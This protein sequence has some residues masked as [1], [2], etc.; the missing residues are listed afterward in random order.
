[1]ADT[2]IA[3]TAGSGTSVDTRTESTNGNHRQVVVLGDPTTNAGVASVTTNGE[4][5]TSHTDLTTTG[6]I[7]AQDAG[8]STTAGEDN[9]S[10][11]TGTPTASSSVSATAAGDST[12]S[13][14]L[15]GT[16][17]GTVQFERSLDGGTTYTPVGMF[18]AGSQYTGS[19][20]TANGMFHGNASSA[21]TVRVRC[22]AYG[23]GTVTVRILTGAGTGTVT[24]GNPVIVN[25]ARGNVGTQR[26]T[27]SAS[28]AET[29]I[30]TAAAGVLNDVYYLKI[31]N[32]SS[33][34]LRV[35]LRDTT[36][37]TIID[38]YYVPAND[39]RGFS[40]TVPV[41][42]TTANTNWTAQCSASV[43]DVRITAYFI[44]NR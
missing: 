8:S 41:P 25:S 20:A 15:S 4:L 34:G 26:T 18:T 12:F 3:I 6:S 33:T 10:I 43:T 32:T 29:T 24:V 37:G 40:L 5:V 17:V 31:S 2:A 21:T 22:T 14:Q 38:D 39:T 7:T 13:V 36:A 16:W 9:Q 19:T 27:I 28:T 44:K 42:Q 30:V 1:M 35:D 23:S 11:I